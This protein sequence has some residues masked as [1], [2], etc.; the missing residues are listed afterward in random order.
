M[1]LVTLVL[2]CFLFASVAGVFFGPLMIKGEGA[3]LAKVKDLAESGIEVEARMLNRMR[4][5]NRGYVEALFEFDTPNGAVRHQTGESVS[6]AMVVGDL[7]PVV[8]HPDDVRFVKVG[9]MATVRR[10]VR[11]RRRGVRGAK[12]LILVSLLTGALATAG[13]ILSPA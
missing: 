9:T 6:P 12:R 4:V 2:V 3:L 5:G 13:L 1:I 7:Y 11:Y 8:Y 10:E